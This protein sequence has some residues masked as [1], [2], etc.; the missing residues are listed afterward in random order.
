MAEHVSCLGELGYS[1]HIIDVRIF[2]KQVLCEE[3]RHVPQFNDNL[4]SD[5]GQ[6]CF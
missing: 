4:L 5:T 6:G 3:G 2:A 1:F